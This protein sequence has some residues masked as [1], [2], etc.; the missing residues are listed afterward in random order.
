MTEA[1]GLPLAVFVP[2]LLGA[3]TFVLGGRTGAALALPGAVSTLAAVVAL[4][5]AA[6]EPTRYALGGW[7]AP[8]GIALHADRLTAALL[9]LVAAIFPA[10][11]VYARAYFPR[12]GHEARY[13]WPLAWLLWAALNAVLLSSDLFNL[14]VALELLTL[15]AVGLVALTGKP[16]AIAASL[17]YLV[18]ALVGSN[19]FLLAVALLY[20]ATG[21]LALDALAAVSAHDPAVVLAVALIVVALALKTALVPIHFWLPAAHGAAA[22]PVS[23][24]LSALVIKASFYMLVRVWLVLA[25]ALDLAALGRVLTLLGAVA[26]LW[27][28]VG[29]LWQQRLKLLVAYSTV[30]QT[31]YL[32][33]IFGWLVPG[34]G[35]SATA[36]EAGVLQVI[37]HG[38][39]KAAMFLAAGSLVLSAGRDDFASLRGAA[40]REPA[41]VF[42]FGLAGA[43]LIGLPPSAGFAAKWQLLHAAFEAGD[44]GIAVVIVAGGLLAAVYV[45]RVLQWAFLAGGDT[46]ASDTVA[47]PL[48]IVPLALALAAGSGGLFGAAV[49]DF[50]ELGSVPT[51]AR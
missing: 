12:E 24:L 4:A 16:E 32:F 14:F 38:L 41:L 18:A 27:G 8:L 50:L 49:L 9:L 44:W 48:R 45:F 17:R 28:S 2:L 26:V 40:I 35:T 47:R 29:A 43:S 5:G 25:P 46:P 22:A 7:I 23:A 33:L 36:L 15:C 3:M 42:A 30:A 13:F 37:A 19:L 10:V 51:G 34:I 39:A 31:G 1:V 11:F 20:G 6:A 21:A